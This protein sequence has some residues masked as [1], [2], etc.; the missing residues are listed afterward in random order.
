MLPSHKPIPLLP[1][2]KLNTSDSGATSLKTTSRKRQVKPSS[3]NTSMNATIN[4]TTLANTSLFV[5]V[6]TAARK[7]KESLTARHQ[8]AKHFSFT[9]STAK[10]PI[11]HLSPRVDVESETLDSHKNELKLPLPSSIILKNFK[12]CLSLYEQGEIL[13][14]ADAY[15]LGKNAERKRN[16]I[17][18]DDDRGDYRAI[19]GEHI[20]YR[21]ELIVP[22]GRGSFGQVF[23]AFDHKHKE[24]IALKIIR[25]KSKFHRQAVFEVKILKHLREADSEDRYNVVHLRNYF[26]FRKHVC[27]AFELMSLNLYDFIKGNQFRGFS[28]GLVKRFAVQLLKCLQLLQKTQI[29]HCDL[30]PENILLKQAHRSGIKV[31]DFGSSCYEDETVY[32]YIQSRFYR[33]PEIILGMPYGRPIDMWSFGCILA[34]LYCGYPL[35]P[36]ESEHE[37]LLC[38]MEVKGLPPP[39]VMLQSSRKKLFF[40]LSQNPII[41]PNT[42]GKLRFPATKTLAE[43]IRCSDPFF[44]DFLNR[45]IDWNPGTRLTPD[46]AMRHAWIAESQQKLVNTSQR[47]RSAQPTKD[48][49]KAKENHRTKFSLCEADSFI[50]SHTTSKKQPQTT[51]NTENRTFV[52]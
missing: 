25:N 6:R 14:H 23:K 18:F 32:T 10:F 40:D 3:Q 13:S 22:L 47:Q 33:A 44:I 34:E 19:I 39:E 29:I 1:L 7:T 8:E 27:I 5:P 52:F 36:G 17:S 2:T 41:K 42:R 50:T 4:P 48:L 35:F 20:C 12:S 26:V 9:S 45:T 15:Y 43:I 30:K 24:E 31:I 11:P 28:L 37:Q 16:S 46:E 51:R 21:Y 38:M 49:S